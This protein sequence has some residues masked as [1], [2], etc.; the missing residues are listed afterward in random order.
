MRLLITGGAGFIGSNFVRYMFD[1]Y[2][3][4]KI[5]TLD[6]LT[7]A[8]NL[9]NLH[10]IEKNPNYRFVKG[11][12]CDDKI[13]NKVMIDVDYV[14]HFAAETHVDRS[15]KNA[16]NFVDTNVRGTYVLLDSARKNDIK[17]FVHISTDEVY[18]NVGSGYSKETDVLAPRNPY[19]ATKAGSEL[20]VNSFF[21]T[22]DLP[23]IITRSSNNF[24]PYQHPEKL[25]PLFVTNLMED[26]GVPLYGD[27]LNIRDWIYVKDNCEAIDFIMSNGM[28]GET[29]N[30]GGGNEKRNIDVARIILKE[31]GKDENCIQYVKDR[32]GHDRRYAMGC[33]KIKKLGWKHSFKFE[34]ALKETIE[35]YKENRSWW[36]KLK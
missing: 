4:C 28:G 27:G 18:G 24:G 12:I 19:A 9:D 23:V 10:D 16:E 7:Y 17:R 2:P 20:L 6:K 14:I 26:K 33:K 32:L 36:K 13:V 21:N 29:Y 15:I 22:H 8:G 1:K 25:I 31:F 3:D 35:W 11:D 5:T 34:E 30:I